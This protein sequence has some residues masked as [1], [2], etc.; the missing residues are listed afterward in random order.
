MSWVISNYTI[1]N[2]VLIENFECHD[3][4]VSFIFQQFS[5]KNYMMFKFGQTIYNSVIDD[6]PKWLLGWT[7]NPLSFTRLRSSRSIVE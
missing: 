7:A 5:K 6:I 2:E 4:A 3:F 1:H